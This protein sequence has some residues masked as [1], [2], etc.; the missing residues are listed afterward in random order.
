MNVTK[1][2]SVGITT[3][4]ENLGAIE[5]KGI[6]LRTRF[7]PIQ[8]KDLQWSWS[9]TYAYNKGRIKRISNALQAQNLVNRDSTGTR[10]LPIYEE[11][12]SLTD[13]KVVPQ[14]VSIR[15]P[16]RKSTSSATARTPSSTM[17]ATK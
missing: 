9:L 14:R 6:E 11:G 12:G 3:A 4:R 16:V 1:A 2:P 8:T 5:N 10:P 7:V 17:H 13:L 15:P